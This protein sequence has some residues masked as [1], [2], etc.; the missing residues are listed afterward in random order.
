[1]MFAFYGVTAV[2][3]AVNQIGGRERV[4]QK[5]KSRTAPEHVDTD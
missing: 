1:V 3:G 4:E 5:R 2:V